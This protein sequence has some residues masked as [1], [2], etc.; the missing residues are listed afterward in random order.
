MK[1]YF[2]SSNEVFDWLSG[3][4]NLEKGQKPKNFRID[5]MEALSQLAGNPHK[6]APSVHI[7][8][9]KGKGSVTSMLAAMLTEAGLRTSRY[10][11]PHVS[12]FRERICLDGSFFSENTYCEAGDELRRITDELL[13]SLIESKSAVLFDTENADGC[14]PTY[15]E[16]LTLYFFFCSR[17]SNC[18]IMVIETGLG[19][20]LD[21]TNIV[22]PL[23]SVITLI[24][25]EH[26]SFLGNTIA[27]IAGEKAGIIKKGKPVVLAKQCD[28]ALEVFRKKAHETES[29]LVYF[30][31]SAELSN[32]NI[33]AQ[34]TEFSL[35]LSGP[36]T[37]FSQSALSV[38]IPGK[39]QAENAA[40]AVTALAVISH[41][42]PYMNK[43][44]QRGNYDNFIRKGL[45]KSVIPARFEKILNNPTLIIDGAHTA[46]SFS[47]CTETFCSL[48]G[49]GGV[50]IFGCAADKDPLPMAKN[51]APL[52]S[53]I[54]IT[55]P[56][57]FKASNPD[58]IFKAF[59]D[60]A[61]NEKVMLIKGTQE[62]VRRAV[63]YAKEKNFSILGT[64]SFYL[65]AE[66][67]KLF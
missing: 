61:G 50:L 39:V 5:R 3:F 11:S 41:N 46:E 7:A 49:E 6:C 15:W 18:D 66:I 21:S 57:T 43:E 1:N 63:N 23:V 25:L 38:P 33:T 19:G 22:D 17:R 13:P 40:L 26:T 20:R 48:C 27:E 32:I 29:P 44:T 2:S 58:G 67:R 53:K 54:I 52:F 62:A 36:F 59:A 24:E 31:E 64:G 30:P 4:I 51:A 34:G 37:D 14:W 12:D 8:G 28:E 9:S 45:A 10:M 35:S 55:T 65:A 60:A 56:G 47:L 16:L 42:F